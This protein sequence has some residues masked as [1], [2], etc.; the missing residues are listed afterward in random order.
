MDAWVAFARNGNPGWDA[1]D[2][3]SRSTYVFGENS[4]SESAPYDIER[5][6][7]SEVP[8]AFLGSL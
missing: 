5:E 1:Y 8:G 3:A 7:W 4:R 2:E 6:A